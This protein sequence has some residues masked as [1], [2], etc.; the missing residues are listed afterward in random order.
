MTT[1]NKLHDFDS[2]GRNVVILNHLAT[3]APYRMEFLEESRVELPLNVM[4]DTVLRNPTLPPELKKILEAIVTK[5]EADYHS[6]PSA[7]EP[8]EPIYLSLDRDKAE[9]GY[10]VSAEDGQ[11]T[12]SL[13][14]HGQNNEELFYFSFNPSNIN[15][16]VTEGA[17]FDQ[18]MVIL[19]RK[20]HAYAAEV[21]ES[22]ALV[23]KQDH[24]PNSPAKTKKGFIRRLLGL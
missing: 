21:E 22:Y 12:H 14:I 1:A 5:V 11:L 18:E 17:G 23:D 6:T 15:G 24:G 8:V 2:E 7:L 13:W 3:V 4:F 10:S 16:L 19:S 20:L 9:F